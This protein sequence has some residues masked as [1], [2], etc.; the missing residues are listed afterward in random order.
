[1]K[2][3]DG[4]ASPQ[5]LRSPLSP[6]QREIASLVAQGFPTKAIGAALHIS[7]WTVA[8]HLRRLYLRFGVNTRASMVARLLEE[9]LLP[10][11]QR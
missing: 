2:A 1:M 7:P 8:T 4:P 9:G 3:I 10:S 6:R 5:S 11:T